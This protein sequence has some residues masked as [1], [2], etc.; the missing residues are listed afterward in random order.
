L[1]HWFSNKSNAAY[2]FYIK[3]FE[4]IYPS[5][6][7]S[8]GDPKFIT[9]LNYEDLKNFHANHYHPSNAFT[10]SYGRQDLGDIL[11]PLDESVKTFSKKEVVNEVK[12]PI[13]LAES[14]SVVVKGPIDPL[15]DEIK[16]FKVSLS[17]IVGESSDLSNTYL[18]SV[19]SH[20][21]TDG[22]SSPF[23]KALIDTQIG[24]DFAVNTGLDTTP[25]K[26]IF[27]I[28]LQGMEEANIEV[29]KKTVNKVLSDIVEHGI[30][31]ERIEAV[32]NQQE[33]ADKEVHSNFGL[34]LVYKLFPRVFNDSNV[35]DSLDNEKV[36]N[37][38]KETVRRDPLI[39]QKL[40]S[41]HL[42]DKPIFEFKMIPS[43]YFEDYIVQEETERLDRATVSLTEADKEHIY[44]R[45]IKL[46]EN[47][48]Q[49]QDSSVLPSLSAD[50]ISRQGK[51]LSF[52]EHEISSGNSSVPLISRKTVTRGLSYMTLMSDITEK[53][54]ATLFPFLSL[55]VD[56]MQNVGTKNRSME[57]FE[58]TIKLNTGGISSSLMLTSSPTNKDDFKLNFL[59]SGSSLDSKSP[60]VF[61]LLSEMFLEPTLSNVEKLKPIIT[62]S[63]A[64][65]LNALA[66]SGHSYAMNHSSASVS[67]Q[68]KLKESFGGVLQIQLMRQLAELSEE[69]LTKLL[70]P[71][72]Y[73]IQ[74]FVA[75]QGGWKSLMIQ[76][77]EDTLESKKVL[78][79]K[80]LS[81]LPDPENSN[82]LLSNRLSISHTHVQLPFQVAYV[83]VSVPGV[84]YDHK[85]GA[86]LQILSNILTHKYLHREI[87]EKGGAYGGGAKYSGL[88]GVFSFYSYRDPN[89]ENSLEVVQNAPRWLLNTALSAQYLQE[90]KLSIF[91]GIDSPLSPRNELN[92]VFY[93]GVRDEQRQQ[94]RE[95]LLDVSLDDLYEVAKIYLEPQLV[96]FNGAGATVLG[97]AKLPGWKVLDF[98]QGS[99]IPGL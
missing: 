59:L 78:L 27:T 49:K 50:D 29:F 4:S 43:E 6:N 8:G 30:P 60:K 56:G 88:D 24:V 12:R 15:Y 87:R 83:G 72:L 9:N 46:L 73:E 64:N 18:W 16:Q 93:Y 96:N 14:K 68:R 10:F 94:R 61:E 98:D 79:E 89:P 91:Q 76:P 63:V 54:P 69:Q 99:N 84:S 39:F 58:N 33:L 42:V 51:K 19:L 1:H 47:Q 40:I 26:N 23:H 92:D 65:S 77:Q 28:G 74:K 17:W 55:Y 53:V 5:L 11:A 45:G 13:E 36:L 82:G 20:L 81:Q 31:K 22:H 97:P 71:K 38:F 32:I 37:N 25:A 41:E 62:A 7:S 48:E 95:N 85:H 67:L 90:A 86:A 57:D 3:Y 75:T 70:V 80:F 21:L 66:D 35:L 52:D 2:L 44:D 34:S